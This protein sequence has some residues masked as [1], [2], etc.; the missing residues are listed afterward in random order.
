[1]A[2]MNRKNIMYNTYIFGCIP[3]S[4]TIQTAIGLSMFSGSGN[5]EEIVKIMSDVWVCRNSKMAAIH[6]NR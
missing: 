6:R 3:V 5:T 1:M 2:A 4:N